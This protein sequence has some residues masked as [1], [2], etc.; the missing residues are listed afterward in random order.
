M[1][2]ILT[3]LTLLAAGTSLASAD[4]VVWDKTPAKVSGASVATWDVSSSG[5]TWSSGVG[6]SVIFTID[7]SS[8][9]T[10]SGSYALFS[11]NDSGFNGLTAVAIKDG[12]I[13]F[14][15]W[16]DSTPTATYALRDISA[17]QN[18]TFVFNRDKS[19]NE[20]L[21]IYADANFGS[22]VA[23]LT[24][25]TAQHFSGKTWDELNFGGTTEDYTGN[26]AT[27]IPSNEDA[28][29]F[30]LLAAGYTVGAIATQDDLIQYSTSAIPEPSAF[31]LIAG[32]GALALVAA[33][34][35]R[36]R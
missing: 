17:T 27:V 20:T 35:R 36:S 6:E 18:L 26:V 31:G 12:D 23:T 14:E 22:K 33:R 28:G 29:S 8:I 25:K 15:N 9:N 32:M 30:T 7:L 21:D 24:G 1:K 5:L 4:V 10:S 3:T 13:I 19:N 2:N 11:V 16:N 34:R